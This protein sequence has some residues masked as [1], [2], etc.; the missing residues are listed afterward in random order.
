[1][2]ERTVVCAQALHARPASTVVAAAGGF[3]A[4]VAIEVDGR[5]ANAKSVLSLMAL[6]VAA[7]D[8]VVVRADG[9]DADA[10]V[11]AIDAVLT[12]VGSTDG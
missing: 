8:R 6:D 1:V 7:G 11:A 5:T 2:S 3:A 10:A 12:A 9:P 4:A